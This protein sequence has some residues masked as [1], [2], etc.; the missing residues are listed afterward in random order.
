MLTKFLDAWHHCL[1]LPE[2]FRTRGK[3][4]LHHPT[5]R[6]CFLIFLYWNCSDFEQGMVP[7]FCIILVKYLNKVTNGKSGCSN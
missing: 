3:R 5:V 6:L 2:E 7:C 4:P 1:P